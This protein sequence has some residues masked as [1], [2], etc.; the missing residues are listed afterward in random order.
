MRRRGNSSAVYGPELA[1]TKFNFRGLD[2]ASRNR[3]AGASALQHGLERR[4]S[5]LMRDTLGTFTTHEVDTRMV[6]LS[7]LKAALESARVAITGNRR[8]AYA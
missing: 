1:Q 5:G 8:E 3:L 6:R 7:L 2:R 4:C